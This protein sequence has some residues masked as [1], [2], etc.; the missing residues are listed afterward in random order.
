MN[1]SDETVQGLKLSRLLDAMKS[2]RV[3]THVRMELIF[4]VS[5][6]VFASIIRVI[7]FSQLSS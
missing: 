6:T 7:L 2:S 4:Y 3:I 1:M 5:E